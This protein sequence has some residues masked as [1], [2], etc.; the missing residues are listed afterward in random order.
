MK[1]HIFPK[2]LV[3]AILSTTL[4]LYSYKKA[5]VPSPKPLKAQSFRVVNFNKPSQVFIGWNAYAILRMPQSTNTGG[6]C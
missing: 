3:L 5:D 1:K 6:G 4:M 2:L